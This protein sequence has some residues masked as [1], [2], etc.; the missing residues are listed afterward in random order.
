MFPIEHCCVVSEWLS[1]VT[2]HLDFDACVT[3][4]IEACCGSASA[5]HQ[6]VDISAKHGDVSKD[7]RLSHC[8]FQ[9]NNIIDDN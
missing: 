2:K 7:L 8:I 4:A 5:L 6:V 9:M 3:A 1:L